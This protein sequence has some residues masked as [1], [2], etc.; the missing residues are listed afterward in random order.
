LSDAS[1]PAARQPDGY[2]YRYQDGVY[3]GTV[4]RFNGGAEVNGGK[5]IEAIPYYFGTPPATPTQT[6][7]TGISVVQMIQALRGC[8]Q[9]L[10]QSSDHNIALMAQQSIVV[11]DALYR[12]LTNIFGD[13]EPHRLWPFIRTQYEIDRERE[14]REFE[15][16]NARGSQS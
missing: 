4:I 15:A 9:E 2:A 8:V 7:P 3:N 14:I 11:L 5:F 16:E 10:N 6:V 1:T 13:D 12:E